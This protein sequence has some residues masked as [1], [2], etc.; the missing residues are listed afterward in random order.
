M[1]EFAPIALFVYNRPFHTRQTVEA[2]QKNGLSS[3]SNLIIFSDAPKSAAQTKAVLDVRQY[4]HQIKGFKSVTIIEQETN[5]GLA[6][7]I[8]DGVTKLCNEYGRVIV[9]E[10]DLVVSPYFLNY[11]NTALDIYQDDEMVMHISGYMFPIDNTD[12]PETFFLRT[13]SCWGWAT[14]KRAWRHF[15]KNSKRLLSKF[16]ESTIQRFNMDG[17]NNFWAQVEQNEG[18]LIDTWAIFWYASVFQ[19]DGLCLH[20]RFSMVNNIGLDDTGVHCVKTDVFFTALASKPVS[21]YEKNIFES[22]L[23][24]A[25]TRKFF[26]AI[27]TPTSSHSMFHR[28]WA[29]IKRRLP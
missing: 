27:N 23:A 10:D 2:L 1:T 24:L 5:L 8:I 3:D 6:R 14:W 11:M 16:G 18:G 7:S 9:L 13:A 4:I 17:S 22:A 29:V 12:L 25:R 15:E 21:N 19:N 20:P 26:L 28:I